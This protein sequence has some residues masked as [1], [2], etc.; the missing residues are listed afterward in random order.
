MELPENMGNF[1]PTGGFGPREMETDETGASETATEE[2]AAPAEN[3][4]MKGENPSGNM[5]EQRAFLQGETAEMTAQAATADQT[6]AGPLVI[7]SV[8]C[9]I[10]GLAVA[11]W[12]RKSLNMDA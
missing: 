5:P 3:Q 1:Q 9:L 4:R 10:L 8:L 11:F 7:A 6:A 12:Y 2:A